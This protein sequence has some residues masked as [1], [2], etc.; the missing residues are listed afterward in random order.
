VHHWPTMERDHPCNTFSTC[1]RTQSTRS[2]RRRSVLS[3]CLSVLMR[4]ATSPALLGAV[5]DELTLI[6]SIVERAADGETRLLRRHVRRSVRRDVGRGLPGTAAAR[7]TKPRARGKVETLDPD[8]R[9]SADASCRRPPSA[10]LK[11]SKPGTATH[12]GA[13]PGPAPPPLP[14]LDLEHPLSY[15]MFGLHARQVRQSIAH[16]RLAATIERCGPEAG[17]RRPRRRIFSFVLPETALTRLGL[18]EAE[19]LR[20]LRAV[21]GRRPGRCSCPAAGEACEADA[22]G[23]A[24][25]L[26]ARA[27]SLARS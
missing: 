17:R 24:T 4:G 27:A 21:A 2:G 3:R 20:E 9:C 11:G 22:A 5:L 18:L 12:A 1:C 10:T 19:E 16:W 23:T 26:E 8:E 7:A 15:W 13:A 6:N 14:E 25:A